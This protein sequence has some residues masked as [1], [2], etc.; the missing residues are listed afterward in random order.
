M[1]DKT[2]EAY[3][4]RDSSPILHRFTEPSM[5]QEYIFTVS[6]PVAATVDLMVTRIGPKMSNM[7]ETVT[8][9]LD[10]F[11]TSINSSVAATGIA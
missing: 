5:A 3:A 8:S 7:P 2:I 1:R 10:Q 11:L 6:I 9:R 4:C